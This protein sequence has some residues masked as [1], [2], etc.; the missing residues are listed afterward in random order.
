MLTLKSGL[1]GEIKGINPF[2]GAESGLDGG[3]ERDKSRWWAEGRLDEECKL[4]K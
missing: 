2:D 1:D 3:N 4:A